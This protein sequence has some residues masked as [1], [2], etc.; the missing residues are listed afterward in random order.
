M[1]L[2]LIVLKRIYVAHPYG[3]KPEN[4]A[5]AE[6]IINKLVDRYGSD[7]VFVSPLHALGHMYNKVD[8]LKG[9]EMCLALLETCHELWLCPGW[10]DSRGCNIEYG[11]AKGRGIP[12][13]FVRATQDMEVIV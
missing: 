9:I 13:Y 2:E 6:K 8:Y 12:I 4:N 5:N 1:I 7:I 3:G 10:E 11:F